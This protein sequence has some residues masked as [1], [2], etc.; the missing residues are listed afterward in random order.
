MGKNV[1]KHRG[2]MELLWFGGV[3][4][5]YGIGI[6]DSVPLESADRKLDRPP[7]EAISSLFSFNEF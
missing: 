2:N 7:L 3:S 4:A 6:M 5:P 1:K